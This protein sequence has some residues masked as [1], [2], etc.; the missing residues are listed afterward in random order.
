MLLLYN[1]I[2]FLVVCLGYFLFLSLVC[3][4]ALL[5]PLS[6]LNL[7]CIFDY[8]ELSVQKISINLSIKISRYKLNIS[9]Y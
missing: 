5:R 6:C 7:V 4:A 9:T 1:I 8:I 2:V 3:P